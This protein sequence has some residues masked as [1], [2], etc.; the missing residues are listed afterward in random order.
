MDRITS[1]IVGAL[2]VIGLNLLLIG[3]KRLF[4]RLKKDIKKEDK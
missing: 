4:I 2:F 1:I 3:L